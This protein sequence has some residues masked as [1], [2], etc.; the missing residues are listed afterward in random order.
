MDYNTFQIYYTLSEPRKI[1]FCRN[2]LIENSEYAKKEILKDVIIP[3]KRG[4][5]QRIISAYAYHENLE[6]TFAEDRI[7][8]QGNSR[9]AIDRALLTLFISGEIMFRVKDDNVNKKAF[10]IQNMYSRITGPDRFYPIYP[11]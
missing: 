3:N 9:K 4:T 5:H 6:I 10:K 2:M 11:N 8:I 1:E 7:C